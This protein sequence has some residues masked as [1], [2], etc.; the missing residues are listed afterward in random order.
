M[1]VR[2]RVWK[3]LCEEVRFAA[4]QEI[5]NRWNKRLVSGTLWRILA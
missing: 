5:S 3:R 2:V 1:R 4:K